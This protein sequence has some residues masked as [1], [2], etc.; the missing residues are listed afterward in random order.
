MKRLVSIGI[1]LLVALALPVGAS[2]FLW[3][4]P[5]ELVRGSAAVVQ[6]EVLKVE[7]FWDRAA[8]V[9]VTEAM[10]RVEEKVFGDTPSV[11]VVRTWGGT[12]NG[13]TVEAH[14]FPKFQPNERVL[15][16]LEAERDGASRVTGYQQGHFRVVRD[17]SGVEMAV[18]TVDAGGHIVT[19]DGRHATPAKAVRLD[20]LKASIRNE[21]RRAGRPI[22]EN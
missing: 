21:A 14:G 9:I 20:E 3:M 1:V 7:S 19:R 6:G 11:V 18:P 2:T 4:E 5:Q 15:L 13:Y 12:V 22:L 17:K 16:Y 8:R 10:V